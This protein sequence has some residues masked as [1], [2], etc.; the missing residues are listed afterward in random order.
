[1]L[2]EFQELHPEVIINRIDIEGEPVSTAF[3]EKNIDVAY[4]NLNTEHNIENYTALTL[5]ERDHLVMVTAVFPACW[6]PVPTHTPAES[7]CEDVT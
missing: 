3:K 6:A 7:G 1:L 5:E 2:D 4:I